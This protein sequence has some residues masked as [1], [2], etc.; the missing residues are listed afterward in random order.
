MQRHKLLLVLFLTALL[1]PIAL[2][3]V[4]GTGR[5]LAGM[6]DAAGAVVLDRVALALGVLWALDLVGLLLTMAYSMLQSHVE[7]G[8]EPLEQDASELE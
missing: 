3:I 4:W 6:N 1:L 8:D 5:L 2:C 7:P